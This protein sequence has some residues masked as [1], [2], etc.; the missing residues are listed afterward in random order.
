MIHSEFTNEVLP[1]RA[2]IFYFLCSFDL[3]DDDDDD[4]N[5]LCAGNIISQ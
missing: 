2:R 3:C 5:H 4:D 1:D